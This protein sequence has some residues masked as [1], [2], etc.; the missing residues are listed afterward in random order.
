MLSLETLVA[1]LAALNITLTVLVVMMIVGLK[2]WGRLTRENHRIVMLLH[3]SS[4]AMILGHETRLQG[5]G[6]RGSVLPHIN[7]ELT[8]HLG[9]GQ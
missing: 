2:N 5:L 6:S 1:I 8:Q 3:V 4:R 7:E 9:A